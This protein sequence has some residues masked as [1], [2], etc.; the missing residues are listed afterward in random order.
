[1]LTYYTP[2][3]LYIDEEAK[4]I[5]KIITSY[6]YKKILL[7]Y[8]KESIK[9]NGLY[10]EIIGSLNDANISFKEVSGVS[11]NP[12]LSFVREALKCD[13]KDIEL[14]LA[15]GGG[16]VIDTAKSL[17][18]SIPSNIDPWKFNN[19]EV[20]PTVSIPIG[21]ILTISAAGSEMSNSCVITNEET[22]AKQGFNSDL[23]RPLFAIMNAKYTLGVSKYQTACGITDI[24]MHTLERYICDK[25][26]MLA[27]EFA[28][29][30]IKTVIKNGSIAYNNPNDFQARK[31]LMLAS[32]FSHNGLTT[33][34]RPH[35]FRCHKFEHV[36]SGEFDNVSHGAGLAV[37]FPA[38][39]KYFYKNEYAFPKFLR[40]AYDVFNVKE[41][42]NKESDCYQ[43]IIELENYFKSIGMPTSME[44]LGIDKSYLEE[45]SLKL[46]ANKT[47]NIPDI[48]P[49]DYD[50]AKDIFALM[51]R[52]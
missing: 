22:K 41:T 32:S 37:C 43:G 51:W 35:Y 24:L 39:A 20:S 47:K 5:G 3:K 49:I 21:V 28:I 29:G 27:D 11:A 48:I 7:V 14:I 9:K 4:N 12:K 2:T 8:G 34:G 44:D 25:D 26:S 23:I 1:M 15:V 30:L 46:T 45:F 6:G 10:D 36:I 40:L 19:Y 33:I 17:A 18:V 13:L 31:E 38:Y 50:A 52:D 16:S 42:N